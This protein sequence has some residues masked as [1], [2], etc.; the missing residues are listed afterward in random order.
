MNLVL[1]IIIVGV[2]A[3]GLGALAGMWWSR[4]SAATSDS[5]IQEMEE[6]LRERLATE[7]KAA[8]A[9]ALQANQ[10]I[11]LQQTKLVMENNQNISAHQLHSTVVPLQNSLQKME[12][13]LRG[14]EQARTIAYTSMNEQLKE[15][16]MAQKELRT[17]AGALVQAL[18]D[19]KARG[20]W[21]ELQLRRVVEFAG[22]LN[23]VDFVEQVNTTTDSGNQ[24]PDMV[25]KMPNGRCVVVDAKVPLEAYTR[26]IH[27]EDVGEKRRLMGEHGRQLKDH[28]KK[29]G[30]KKY[31]EEWK[32]PEFVVLFLNL[33]SSLSA[34]L[35]VEPQR[36]YFFLV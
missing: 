23:Y 18:R 27:V 25:I 10:E 14:L 12:V 9:Q 36:P 4:K 22:M 15:L 35:E 21:G 24:R 7:F 34:A 5:D 13:E 32:S 16:S 19:P 29:L 33:E 2:L 20:S 11:L 8:A 1:A 6:R 28:F 17:Q 30:S 31:F 3:L 26:A